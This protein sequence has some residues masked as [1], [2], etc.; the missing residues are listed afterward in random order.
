MDTKRLKTLRK[1]YKSFSRLQQREATLLR[2]GKAMSP[3]ETSLA[4]VNM[5]P[6]HKILANYGSGTADP[7]VVRRQF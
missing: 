6:F 1:Q 5:S 2:W 3:V 7:L 4:T